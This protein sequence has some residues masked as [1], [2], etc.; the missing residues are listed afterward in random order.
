MRVLAPAKL[1]LHLRVGPPRA[2]GFHPLLTWMCTVALFDNLI[3]DRAPGGEIRLE[4]DAPGVPSDSRN[5]VSRAA[6]ALAQT[7]ARARAKSPQAGENFGLLV[8]L[9]KTIP[10][11]AGLAGG[12]SDGAY[13]LLALNQLWQAGWDQARIAEFAANFGSDLS[14]FVYGPSAICRGR[15]E[16]VRPIAPPRPRWALLVL[17]DVQMPTPAV[18]RRFDEMNL[19]VAAT[20]EHEPDFNRWTQLDSVSLLPLLVNDLETPAFAIEPKLG[21]LRRELEQNL[22]RC[23]RM[24]GSGSSLFTLYDAQAQ[25]ASAAEIA[26]R[27]F[28]VKALAAELAPTPQD[29]LNTAAAGR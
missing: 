2:D 23:V 11:G 6:A 5:L 1:N 29:D 19:G 27:R 18:Y 9:H 7:L 22:G 17:P 15:G 21:I 24:S 26:A 20:I 25:A 28:A 10:V 3:V 4:C 16:I 13:T 12:S 8:R 14:F